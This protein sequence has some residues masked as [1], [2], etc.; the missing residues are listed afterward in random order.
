VEAN[1]VRYATTVLGIIAALV[2]S[3]TARAQSLSLPDVLR[4]VGLYVERYFSRVQ[5]IVGVEKVVVQPVARDLASDGRARTLVYELRLDWSPGAEP[6]VRRDLITVDGRPPKADEEPMCM[7]TAAITPEP[8][9]FLLPENQSRFVF[10]DGGTAK[11]EGHPVRVLGYRTRVEEPSRTTWQ[12]GCGS[13]EPG[14]IQGKVWVDTA[15]AEVHRIDSG[16]VGRIDIRVPR[17]QPWT[18]GARDLTFER[19]GTSIRYR[20][21]RFANP[22]ETFL[23]PSTVDSLTVIRN[24][25]SL[26]VRHEYADYRRFVTGG[27]IVQ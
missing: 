15:S 21:V 23:L 5:S 14:R 6:Y 19:M 18:F 13:V 26:R 25:T 9:E 11:Y 16:F 20:P 2:T 3:P 22:D 1:A 27:R 24:A 8:L 7:D 12:E 17:D 10:T 4:D